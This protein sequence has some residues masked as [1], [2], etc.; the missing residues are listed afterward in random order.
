M[1]GRRFVLAADRSLMSN[2]RGNFLFGFLSCGPYEHIPKWVYNH[3]MCPAVE[4][5]RGTGEAKVAECGLRRVESSLLED[6]PTRDLIVAHPDYVERAIGEETTVVGVSAMDPLGIGPVTSSITSS[7]STPFNRVMFRELMTRINRLKDRFGFRTVLGGSGTWQLRMFPERAAP[8]RFDS[9]VEGEA[10]TAAPQIFQDLEDGSAEEH[11]RCYTNHVGEVPLIRGP[12]IN[13]LIE[14]M[15]GCGRGCSFCDVTRRLRRDFPIERLKAEAKINLDYGFSAV[16]LQSDEML[17]YGCDNRDFIP[18][19]DAVVEL[20]REIRALDGVE[21]VG[22]THWTLSSVVAAPE[23]IEEI[24]RLNGL[25]PSRWL[26]VQ[27]GLESAAPRIVQQWLAWKVKPFR[28]EEWPWVVREGVRILNE[29]YYF[30]AL[31][32]IVGFPNETEDETR[33]TI[34]L[35]DS[36]AGTQGIIAPLLYVDYV[37]A[38]RS[39]TFPKMSV[40]QF[41]LYYKSWRHNLRQFDEKI[42]IATRAFNP[43]MRTLSVLLTRLGTKAILTYLRGLAKRHF[44]ALPEDIIRRNSRPTHPISV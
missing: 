4:A 38:E 29:N 9:L 40:A 10:D 19:Q 6:Y 7:E 2:F 25:G 26:A 33:A 30:P 34:D 42:W 27:P 18:N 44:G 8:F 16:W 15:R 21:A 17:L 43:I 12:T 22:S 13:G 39:M 35:V 28:N 32:L 5:D 20:F 14:A 31:T 36:L 41:E 3:V 1:K 11:I 23:I 37:H 24:S